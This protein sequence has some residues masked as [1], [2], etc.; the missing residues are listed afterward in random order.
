[1]LFNGRG[2]KS[3]DP[4]KTTSGGYKPGKI[5]HGDDFSIT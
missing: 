5:T 3:F 4:V 2:L 1:V